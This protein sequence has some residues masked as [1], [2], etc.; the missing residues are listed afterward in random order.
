MNANSGRMVMVFFLFLYTIIA[1]CLMDLV[2]TIIALAL[3]VFAT[4]LISYLYVRGVFR[5]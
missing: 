4:L 2:N 1:G 5:G 3:I